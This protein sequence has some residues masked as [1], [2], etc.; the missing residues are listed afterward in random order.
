MAVYMD[1]ERNRFRRMVMCHMLA[2]TITELHAMASAIGMRR[3]WFQPFSFPHYDLSLG[4]RA[5]AVAKGA[6]VIERREVAALMRRLRA[7]QAFIAA[8]KAE[9]T[10]D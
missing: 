5:D 6:L 1:G 4:R 9:I 7:D 3:E 8:W 2:D 10:H